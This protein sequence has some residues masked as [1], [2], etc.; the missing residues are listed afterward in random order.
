MPASWLSLS[1]SFENGVQV[2]VIELEH[3]VGKRACR[4]SDLAIAFEEKALGVRTGRRDLEP[5]RDIGSARDDDGIPESIDERGRRHR[6]R[7]TRGRDGD[8]Q[9]GENLRVASR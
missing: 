7:E 5:E 4:R 1:V 8:E 2:V 3:A 6:R 9:R